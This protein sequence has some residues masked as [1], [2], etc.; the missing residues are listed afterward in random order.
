MQFHEL[1]TI[2]DKLFYAD[3]SSYKVISS[4]QKELLTIIAPT[5]DIKKIDCKK[6]NAYIDYL[7]KK[8][9]SNKTINDKISYLSKLLTYAVKNQLIP[10]KPYIP[11]LK[12]IS[13]KEKYLTQ[14]EIIKMLKWTHTNKQKELRQILLI[15]LY[16]GLRINNILK[17]NN[18]LYKDNSLY[19]YDSKVNRNFILPV[20]N[21]IKYIIANL[22]GFNIDYNQCYYIF[23]K[24]KKELNLDKQITIHTLRHTFCSNLIQKGIPIT[25]IQKLANHKKIQT[26]MR[27]SHLSKNELTAAINKL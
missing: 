4:K 20:S 24:M 6:I 19:I 13:T 22:K 27:Y 1:I 9:N 12:V 11:Y 25:P 21:K 10:Y 8:G 17:L 2:T 16:T 18:Q 15:G 14:D 7:Q 5:L 3:S 23:N 26:T